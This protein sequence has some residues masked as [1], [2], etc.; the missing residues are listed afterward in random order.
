MR[1]S[2]M[3]ESFCPSILFPDQGAELLGLEG[4]EIEDGR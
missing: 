4:E 2:H 1:F 3:K